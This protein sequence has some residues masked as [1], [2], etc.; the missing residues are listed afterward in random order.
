M[1]SDDGPDPRK[2][3]PKLCMF[4]CG[5][6]TQGKMSKE[7]W[8]PK[9]LWP[10][11]K[12]VGMKTLPAHVSCNQSFADDNDYFRTIVSMYEGSEK[13]SEAMKVIGGPLKKLMTE[14]RGQFD[15]YTQND[16]KVRSRYTDGGIY[17]GE[18]LAFPI[19]DSRM[20]RVLANI[21][22]GLFYTV[23]G[24]PLE[25]DRRILI[26]YTKGE[27]DL[28]VQKWANRMYGWVGFG[29]DTFLC[30]YTFVEGFTDIA[31]HLWFYKNLMFDAMSCGPEENKEPWDKVAGRISY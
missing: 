20:Y 29:D 16:F 8:V 1:R 9:C 4:C 18:Q 12:P 3:K 27:N 28:E 22:R 5:D 11:Q 21:V 26:N 30:R 6:K 25:V 24:R 2:K 19:D 15:R 31:C 17:L 13:H 23:V 10:D 14:R 7:H